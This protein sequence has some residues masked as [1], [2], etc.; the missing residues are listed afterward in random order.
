MASRGEGRRVHV[1]ID[2]K[3]LVL[4]N[5]DKVLYPE[6]G[7]TKGEVLDYYRQIAPAI[8]PHLAGRP[9]TLVRAPDGPA[10]PRFFE[11]NCPRHHP[12]WVRTAPGFEAT[13]GTKGCMVDDLPTLV[14]LANLAALELHTHQWAVDDPDHPTA[15][16]LDLDPGEPAGMVECC[17]VALEL[18]DMLDH[19]D[20]ACVA[21]TSG[22]KGLH[23]SVPLHGSAASDD[24]TKRFA[25]G[26]GQV[27]E[28]RDPKHVTVDMAKERR[29]GKVFVDWSQNDRHKTTVCVYSLRN[30]PRGTV[31]APVSWDEVDDVAGR[32]RNADDELSFD[33]TDVVE[34]YEEYGDLYRDSLTLQQELPAL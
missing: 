3:T 11:K 34:R 1:D 21:K 32:R 4:S 17:R 33:T 28:S 9:P 26:L 7:L 27:L 6:I 8:L 13:G 10:G 20:L 24:E 31:S 15:L 30:R 5:L 18:R 16:V 12:D 23:L 19:F 25:L 14:W 29:G 22:G 2:G